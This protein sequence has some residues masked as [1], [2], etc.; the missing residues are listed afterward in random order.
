MIT[1]DQDPWG[2]N[3]PDP[4]SVRRHRGG[5]FALMCDGSVTWTHV[6]DTCGP[7]YSAA[8]HSNN[9][10]WATHD[11]WHSQFCLGGQPL[12]NAG[13]HGNWTIYGN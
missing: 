7:A 12:G 6:E 5:Q 8:F 4:S 10:D 9:L 1:N 13:V 2:C 11:V 3:P